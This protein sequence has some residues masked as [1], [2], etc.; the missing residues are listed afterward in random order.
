MGK[1]KADQSAFQGMKRDGRNARYV[2]VNVE[3]GPSSPF[4]DGRLPAGVAITIDGG[5]YGRRISLFIRV[6]WN[7]CTLRKEIAEIRPGPNVK[8]RTCVSRMRKRRKFN[9]QIITLKCMPRAVAA[10]RDGLKTL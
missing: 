10:T 2:V 1:P 7:G 5:A 3:G 8:N 9:N 4:D 6:A